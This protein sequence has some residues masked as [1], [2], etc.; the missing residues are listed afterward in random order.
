VDT[1]TTKL[2]MKGVV[3]PAY[4]LNSILGKIPIIGDIV[5][6]NEGLIAFN[7]SV[8]GTYAEPDVG[9][10]PLSGLTPGFLRGIFGVFDQK[11]PKEGEPKLEGKVDN[12]KPVGVKSKSNVHRP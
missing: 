7:Y 3:A 1:N 8:K 11:T 10:N 4:A 5:G 2:D 6:G 12:S 9:V